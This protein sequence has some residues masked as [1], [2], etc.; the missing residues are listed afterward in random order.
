[1]STDPAIGVFMA[2]LS[3]TSYNPDTQ[4]VHSVAGEVT[5]YVRPFLLQRFGDI[6]NST[7]IDA[8]LQLILECDIRAFSQC[9]DVLN[10]PPVVVEYFASLQR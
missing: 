8:L 6:M 9:P 4:G 5:K 3:L 2:S 10:L 1:M 7:K